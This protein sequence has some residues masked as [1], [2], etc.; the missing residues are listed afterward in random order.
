MKKE[1]IF[2]YFWST[3]IAFLV[4]KT[5]VVY[6]LWLVWNYVSLEFILDLIHK[7][8]ISIVLFFVYFNAKYTI[9]SFRINYVNLNQNCNNCNRVVRID[10]FLFLSWI[11]KKKKK[12]RTVVIIKKTYETFNYIFAHKQY[13]SLSKG[14]EKQL[15]RYD[16]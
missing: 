6:K 9:R 11:D 7:I 13:R 10:M 1:C 2:I 8:D 5:F 14:F 4:I 12:N 3:L 15:P 16:H